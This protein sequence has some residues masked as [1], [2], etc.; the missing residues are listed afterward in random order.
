VDLSTPGARQAQQMVSQVT[1]LAS[2]QHT[3]T[4][5]NKGPGPVAVDALVVQ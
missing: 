4:I 1:G 2:G 5:T 3:I